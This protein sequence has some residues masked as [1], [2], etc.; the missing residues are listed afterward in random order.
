[1]EEIN[2]L[3]VINISEDI[4]QDF[5][6]SLNELNEPKNTLWDEGSIYWTISEDNEATEAKCIPKDELKKEK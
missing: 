5:S 2:K 6:I 1:M 4:E 3:Q